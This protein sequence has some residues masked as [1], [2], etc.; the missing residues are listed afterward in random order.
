MVF[1]SINAALDCTMGMATS[2]AGSASEWM[3]TVQR[4]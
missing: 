4:R 2:D 1:F 3:T